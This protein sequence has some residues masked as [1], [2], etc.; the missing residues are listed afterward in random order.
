MARRL[1]VTKGS[2]YWHFRNRQDL[3]ESMIELWEGETRA[4]LAE[5]GEAE[6]GLER[7]GRL[8]ELVDRHKG[9]RPDVAIF[10]WAR[11]DAKVAARV[12]A[13]EKQRIGFLEQ[14]FRDVRGTEDGAGEDALFTYLAFV[15]WLDRASRAPKS[16]PTFKEFAGGLMFRLL[17]PADAAAPVPRADKP[18]PDPAAARPVLARRKRT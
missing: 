9:R 17:P 7:L 1:R 4:L 13:V 2:F 14:V 6:P 8:F 16:T 18:A 10:S 3:F 11:R 5:A 12:G 15:G